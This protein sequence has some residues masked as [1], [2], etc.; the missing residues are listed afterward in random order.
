[1]RKEN[2]LRKEYNNKKKIYTFIYL[3]NSTQ[4]SQ[5]LN[6]ETF[7]FEELTASILKEHTMVAMVDEYFLDNN[8][9]FGKDMNIQYDSVL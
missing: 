8:I 9:F 4:K 5:A 2:I 6:N 3:E 7:K 1:M